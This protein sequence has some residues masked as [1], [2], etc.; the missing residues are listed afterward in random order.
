MN[1]NHRDIIKLGGITDVIEYIYFNLLD[2]L[3]R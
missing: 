1:S 3:R 2:E